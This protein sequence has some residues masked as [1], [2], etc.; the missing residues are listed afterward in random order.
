MS[1]LWGITYL[2]ISEAVSSISPAGV[3]SGRT[4]I[5][6]LV[7]LPIAIHRG[8]L[9][10]ALRV[11]PWVLVF[12][13]L[14]MGGPFLLLSNAERT[15]PSG[16]TGLLVSTVPLW[17]AVIGFVVGD[18]TPDVTVTRLASG[19]PIGSDLEYADEVTLGR[20]LSG[21]RAL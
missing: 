5:G 6:A 7:L 11:W 14:E 13:A 3:V 21:R 15:I 18:R 2:F 1:V 9:R 20:A 19:L 4:L 17:A 8:A 10:P 16:L 12:G